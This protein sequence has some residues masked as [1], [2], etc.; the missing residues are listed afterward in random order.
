MAR[1]LRPWV[2]KRAVPGCSCLLAGVVSCIIIERFVADLAGLSTGSYVQL[3]L[4]AFNPRSRG[5]PDQWV[6]KVTSTSFGKRQHCLLHLL[7]R[8]NLLN[9][10][11]GQRHCVLHVQPKLEVHMIGA[12]PGGGSSYVTGTGGSACQN[13]CP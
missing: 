10:E 7:Q 6:S 5:M 8:L 13:K 12:G 4:V 1:S 9:E 11:V 2:V 3:V